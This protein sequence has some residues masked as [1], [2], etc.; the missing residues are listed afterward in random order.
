MPMHDSHLMQMPDQAHGQSSFRLGRFGDPCYLLD[1]SLP[2]IPTAAAPC[3]SPSPGSHGH[4]GGAGGW[5]IRAPSAVPCLT[6][7]GTGTGI[8]GRWHRHPEQ[9]NTGQRKEGRWHPGA[10]KSL[11]LH[12]LHTAALQERT[13]AV[14]YSR[15]IS[16]SF[17]YYLLS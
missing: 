3:A 10:A 16:L 11:E 6:A 14:L 13:A 12:M 2:S 5:H 7:A 17:S 4:S 1:N 15:T 8:P 9:L